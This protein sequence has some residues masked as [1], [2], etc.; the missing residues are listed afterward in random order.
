MVFSFAG[1]LGDP[2]RRSRATGL[3]QPGKRFGSLRRPPAPGHAA[4]SSR[5]TR[6]APSQG[7]PR[8]VNLRIHEVQVPEGCQEHRPG[9][10]SGQ[11]RCGPRI[12]SAT[13]W[14]LRDRALL[15]A[16]APTHGIIQ[17][18][19]ET[20]AAGVPGT[21]PARDLGTG[22]SVRWATM[23]RSP[24][25]AAARVRRASCMR[26]QCAKGLAPRLRPS[27]QRAGDQDH[28]HRQRQDGAEGHHHR[29]CGGQHPPHVA[30]AGAPR[31]ARKP[32]AICGT[33][34]ERPNR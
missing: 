2:A 34:R 1:S 20:W 22:L 13:A 4:E 27:R 25:D 32:L 8:Q 33:E 10:P 24:D 30:G 17:G 6:A 16:N 14:R 21:R 23:A 18:L 9:G 31:G 3:A 11:Q 26:L 28:P 15:R 12:V 19:P 29:P 5:R 7:E